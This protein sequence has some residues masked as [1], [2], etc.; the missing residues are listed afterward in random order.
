MTQQPVHRGAIVTYL[1]QRERVLVRAVVAGPDLV[2]PDTGTAWIPV[3]TAGRSVTMTEV[4][5]IVEFPTDITS[6]IRP[7]DRERPVTIL[8]GALHL[9]AEGLVRASRDLAREAAY[10]EL[11]LVFSRAV[12]PVEDALC[13]LADAEPGSGLAIVLG[14]LSC[15]AEELDNGNLEGATSSVLIADSTMKRMVAERGPAA[16]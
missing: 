6:P 5:S 12:A 10:G 11:L 3:V 13:L 15:A 1:D 7:V 8:A 2:D 4:D 14:W 16:D 9:L